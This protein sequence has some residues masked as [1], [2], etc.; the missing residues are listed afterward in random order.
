MS[1]TS[2]NQNESKIQEL[3]LN[4]LKAYK[5]EEAFWKQKS[6]QLWLSLGDSNTGYF[7]AVTKMRRAKKKLAIIEDANGVPWHE[8][9]QIAKVVSQYYD[10][11]FTACTFDGRATVS[12]ALRPCVSEQ[13]NANLISDPTYEEVKRALFAIYADKAPGPDGFSA[14]FFQSNWEIVGPAIVSEIQSFFTTGILPA[15]INV[16]HVRLI[17]KVTG[18]KKVTEYRPIALCN[19]FYKIISKI[20]SLRLKPVLG[21]IISE[22]QS[23]F[24]P[25]RAITDNVLIT[26]EVLHYLKSST[27]EKKCP[28]AVK[29][30]MSKAYDRVEWD[31]IQQVLQR[32]GFHE[33]L[34]HLVMQC[35]TTVSYSFLINEAVYGSVTPQRGIRQG[36][37]ISPYLFILCGEVLTGLCKEAE[38]TGSF[39]DIRVARGAPRLN[40]LLFADDTMFFCYSTPEACQALKDILLEYERASGQQINKTK[41]SITFSS[42]TP[43]EMKG[44]AKAILAIT[45]EGGTGKYLGLPEH[46]RRRKKDL[47]TSVVDRIRQR[48][49]SWSSRHLSKAGK[50]VM[51]KSVLTAMPSHSM[52]C[53]QIPVSLCKCIQSELTRFW[54]GGIDEKKKL[55]WVSWTNLSKPKA[56]GGLGFRDIQAFNQALLAKIAWRIL[57]A[58][59]CL[60]AR[61]LTGKYCHKKPFLQVELPTSCSHGWRSIFHG[62]DLLTQNLGKA[63]GNGLTTRVWQDSWISLSADVKPYGPITED[64][65]DLRVS[66][67]LTYDLKWNVKRIKELL[68][69]LAATI[70][71]LQ[72]SQMGVEDAFI[73]QPLTSGIYSTK[74]GYHSAMTSRNHPSSHA[75]TVTIIDWYKDVWSTKCSPK[76]KVFLWSIVQ[77]ALPTGVNLQR[78]GITA[79]VTCPR[80]GGQ[81]ST[82]HIFFSSHLATVQSFE[83][84][85]LEFRQK[86]CLPPSG[87]TINILPWACWQIWLSRNLLIFEGKTLTTD[88]V[89]SRTITAIKEWMAAQTTKEPNQPSKTPPTDLLLSES[90]QQNLTCC[91]T[92]AAWNKETQKAGL[93]WIFKEQRVIIC[94]G[95][96]A[97]N[98][99]SSPILAEALACRSSLRHAISIGIEDLNV[100]SDNQTL[101]R[102]LNSK[103]AHKEIF[104]IVSDI[105]VLA[106]SFH[107]IS[108]FHISRSRNLEADSLCKSVL[109]DPSSAMGFS[110]GRLSLSLNAIS[111][112]EM[113]FVMGFVMG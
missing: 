111:P 84:A 53:F 77:R 51:V 40:H 15:T 85:I 45:K 54:W 61:I 93:G 18:P 71:R 31:F 36:D 109:L 7:H 10:E 82:T 11:L 25:G 12:K 30:D 59:S 20:L 70:Q 75:R 47:F 65:R 105:K 37:P 44:R 49:Q 96:E 24:I 50:M 9:E 17:P 86:P 63:I 80:C 22:N 1:D 23:A 101:I 8:E 43:T 13:M 90:M 2:Q 74:F 67:L 88:E 69:E 108:F 79:A 103:L 29:T 89:A 76:L 6:R 33:K 3:N 28:M 38:R 27:A 66:D 39:Q 16:T 83:S 68:P 91:F 87:I 100:F 98:S 60:L 26:H 110:L 113:G 41:S 73:W 95:S 62:R 102:A 56:A 4:L 92:D 55:C 5:A 46:F 48:A 104:G 78:R 72:P 107:A 112:N 64:A 52:S 21:S 42:K 34:I 97:I 99:I 32:L 106:A 81:E 35:V 14:S 57:T 58:P 19:F 94:K